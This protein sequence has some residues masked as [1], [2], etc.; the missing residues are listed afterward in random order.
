MP[1]EQVLRWVNRPTGCINEAWGLFTTPRRLGSGASGQA[2]PRFHRAVGVAFHAA[3]KTT[4][5][6]CAA[7]RASHKANQPKS[8]GGLSR[9]FRS[10]LSGGIATS[11]Y[12]GR[13]VV[14]A[15][16]AGTRSAR[17]AA[18]SAAVRST[19]RTAV[20]RGTAGRGA[21]ATGV[22]T[23]TRSGAGVAAAARSAAARGAARRLA[24]AGVAAT[25][26]TTSTATGFRRIHNHGDQ[27]GHHNQTKNLTHHVASP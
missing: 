2:E 1:K 18:R 6:A 17:A 24:A 5:I 15:S 13:S 25:A 22:A 19:A 11:R 27:G 7:M 23:A 21:T 9:R 12:S 26:S 16:A 4:R 14:T 8:G 20:R 10:V 3:Q